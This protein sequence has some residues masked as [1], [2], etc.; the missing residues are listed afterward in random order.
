MLK[1]L[2]NKSMK[3][4]RDDP[5]RVVILGAGRGG[6]AMLEMLLEED[7][8][9]VVAV[10][11]IDAH[12]HGFT[13]AKEHGVQVYTD[14]EQAIL[15][16]APCVVFNLTGNEM[17]EEVAA[18]ILGVG[19]VIG[20]LE[21][22][23]MWRMVTDLKKAKKD[24]EFQASH[25]VLTNLVNRR[26][27]LQQVEQELD[28][29]KRYGATCSIV[30]LDLDDF[31][32]VNDHYGH[33]A[34]DEVLKVVT[35]R[36]KHHL[37]GVDTLARWGGEEFLVLLPHTSKEEASTAAEKCLQVIV[38]KEIRL[39][40]S[41]CVQV[42]FSAGIASFDELKQEA[43][44]SALADE[45]LMLADKR[46]YAAKAKGKACIISQDEVALDAL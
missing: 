5:S 46:L 38:S 10:V 43:S 4:L 44:L 41:A 15:A 14:V 45:I 17:V 13:L 42:S 24:L 19:G 40:L 33:A 23:L 22:R 3:L 34:G 11:D 6:T 32:H 31:K 36:I 12:A 20:G 26:F 29:C 25:D 39:G 30:M 35:S 7:L 27:M 28:R 8:V 16:C 9:Q 2:E 1:S 21:A 37:R 18:N